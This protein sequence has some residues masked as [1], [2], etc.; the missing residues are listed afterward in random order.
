MYLF[1][2]TK[3]RN[4]VPLVKIDDEAKRVTE[5]LD[6]AKNVYDEINSYHDTKYAYVVDIKKV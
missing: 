5:I 1:L 4:T 6:S 3:K 2:E